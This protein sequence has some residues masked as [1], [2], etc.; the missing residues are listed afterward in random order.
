VTRIV[1]LA[2]LGLAA[3]QPNRGPALVQVTGVGN[4]ELR[5]G[6]TLELRGQPFPEGRSVDVTL[7]GEVRRPG[8]RKRAGFE[9][10]LSGT[11]ASTRSVTL[12]ITR[13]VERAMTG[14]E[15]ARHATFHGSIEVSFRP[16]VA[17]TPPVTGELADVVLD[18]VPAEEDAA[19]AAAREEKGRRFASFAGLLLERRDG[20]IVVDGVMPDGPAERAGVTAGD[21]LLELD[22][23]RLLEL[24]DLVP[25]AEARVSELAV[26]RDGTKARLLVDVARFEPIAAGKLAPLAGALLSLGL[27]FALLASPLGRGLSLVE[28]RLGERLRARTR[29]APRFGPAT[30]RSPWVSELVALL[31]ASVGPYVAVVAAFAVV[32][33]LGFGRPL[34]ARELDLAVVLVA[35]YAA[36]LLAV[37]LSGA[38]GERGVVARLRR[39]LLVL[40]QALV[41]F[42]G[43]GS[44]LVATGG[45]GVDELALS[46]GP[47]PWDYWALRGPLPLFSFLI[48]VLAQVPD[49]ALGPADPGAP[50]RSD[51]ARR[52]GLPALVGSA[53]LVLSSGL[54]SLAFLGGARCGGDRGGTVV[55][56][57][58]IALL[59]AKTVGVAGLVV[60]VRRLL[61]PFDLADARAPLVGR[62]APAALLCFGASLALSRLATDTFRVALERSAA[63]C[64]VA[65]GL[66]LVLVVA[67]RAFAG[68]RQ[69]AGE[70]GLNPWI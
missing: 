42:A 43:F 41:A 55:S 24:G 48:L 3:C 68:M 2:L 25:A 47:W 27:L 57:A 62:L 22:G 52:R 23:V 32:T 34:V 67:R 51:R 50:I 1:L 39:T 40:V 45:V 38:P 56:L 53:H 10:T 18:F 58:G 54:L 64:S 29:R 28:W 17:G 26:E 60:L 46:Q 12:P 44:V 30:R 9:L 20:R 33:A 14:V 35:S 21:H 70:P 16:R 13:Q 63:A 36:L 4:Q 31:P 11:S 6:D 59:L 19:L 61:G 37:L 66:A 8:E 7:R 15:G 49:A 5:E 69:R 65:I